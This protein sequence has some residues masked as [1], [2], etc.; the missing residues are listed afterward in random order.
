RLPLSDLA[1]FASLARSRVGVPANGAAAVAAVRAS[2][3][4][5]GP[6]YLRVPTEPDAPVGAGTFD[7]GV[8]PELR[9]G[10][11]LTVVGVGPP[12]RLA[13]ELADRLGAVGL[14]VRVLDGASVKPLDAPSILRA[15]RETGAILTVEAHQ[16][17]TGYGARVAAVTAASY[18]VPV[19]R[20]GLP[21]L[22]GGAETPAGAEGLAEYG[23]SPGRLDEEAFELLRA[24]GKAH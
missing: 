22:D 12:L 19:R 16:A 20:V 23:I 1:A 5:E 7:Y 15:A 3:A 24:R 13:L 9:P 17:L 21:D 8:A 18:P 10:G 2:A 14:S 11:D 6:V 4:S